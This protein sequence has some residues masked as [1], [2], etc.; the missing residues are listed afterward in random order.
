MGV[1]VE[2]PGTNIRLTAPRGR[3]DVNTVHAFTNGTMCVTCW[4]FSQE[5]ADEISRTGRVYLSIMSGKTMPPAFVGSETA[6]RDLCVDY[7]GTFPK[8]TPG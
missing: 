3:D 2:F 1:A 5:E 4:Q 6:T 8:Q 7:G